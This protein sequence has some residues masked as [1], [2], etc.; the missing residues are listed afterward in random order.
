[1][2]YEIQ[3]DEISK[4]IALINKNIGRNMLMNTDQTEQE[5]IYRMTVEILD[6]MLKEGMISP[7]EYQEINRLN[8]EDLCPEFKWV[9]A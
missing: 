2:F 5:I 7:E 1:M 9:Y 4:I 3:S 8:V 6:Q